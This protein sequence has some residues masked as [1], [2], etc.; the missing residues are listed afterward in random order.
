MLSEDEAGEE[1]FLNI[2][3]RA[4]TVRDYFTYFTS[5][6]SPQPYKLRFIYS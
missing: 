6:F 2:Y 3:Y 5:E 4:D 1:P